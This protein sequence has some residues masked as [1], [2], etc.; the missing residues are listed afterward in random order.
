M[1]T[2][3]VHPG[4]SMEKVAPSG[5][6]SLVAVTRLTIT[7]GREGVN[8]NIP[9]VVEHC[10]E[11][12]LYVS[13]PRMPNRNRNHIHLTGSA[14]RLIMRR[15]IRSLPA[16]ALSAISR[17][18]AVKAWGLS[19]CSMLSCFRYSRNS[20]EPMRLLPSVKG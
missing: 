5:N 18:S 15:T 1:T 12:G 10:K 3:T 4:K 9:A 13:T 11:T 6:C 17:V 2:Q 7:S 8:V 19:R 14:N 20:S 16:G